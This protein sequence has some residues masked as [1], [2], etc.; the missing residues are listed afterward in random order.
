MATMNQGLLGG[1]SGKVGAVV[2]GTW[3]SI[4]YMRSLAASI[5]NPNTEKQRF[6]RGKFRVVVNFVKTM[7]PFIRVGY[8]GYEQRKTAFNAAISYL[9][10]HAV[11][12]GPDGAVLDYKRVRVSQGSLTAAEGAAATVADG[13]VLLTWTDNSGVGDAKGTDVVLALAF[14]K[15]RG[16]A[17]YALHAGVRAGGR[18]ELPL[19]AGW[20]DEP[21][22][23]YLGFRSADGEEVSNSLCVCDA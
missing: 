17:V 1:F 16:A 20:G 9:M 13:K 6:Q 3:K 21:L 22:A 14:N 11:K 5:H 10:R 8:R 19:P 23:V 15:A 18:A 2:G 4:H 7:A 12:E